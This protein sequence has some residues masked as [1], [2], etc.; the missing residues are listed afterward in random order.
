VSIRYDCDSHFVSHLRDSGLDAARYN[1]RPTIFP[2][3]LPCI[4][5]GR[6]PIDVITIS[7]FR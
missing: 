6:Q 2:L 1:I 3:R 7:N 5:P 4:W